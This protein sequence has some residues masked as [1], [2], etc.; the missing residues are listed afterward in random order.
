MFYYWH[1]NLTPN[2]FNKIAENKLSDA[3]AIAETKFQ[4]SAKTISIQLWRDTSISDFTSRMKITTEAPN[5]QTSNIIITT[6]NRPR[7]LILANHNNNQKSPL[8]GAVEFSEKD[9]T[10]HPVWDKD[11]NT[12]L[13]TK[14]YG[15]PIKIQR[16]AKEWHVAF[17]NPIQTTP[18]GEITLPF[19][20]P[21][22]E[23]AKQIALEHIDAELDKMQTSLNAFRLAIK[24]EQARIRQETPDDI[25]FKAIAAMYRYCDKHQ[26]LPADSGDNVYCKNGFH[27]LEARAVNNS[28]IL[29]LYFPEYKT[30]DIANAKPERTVTVQYMETSDLNEF[31]N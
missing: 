1:L 13:S 5:N 30:D 11:N 16:N 20:S 6:P 12:A 18:D 4:N 27:I 22:P 10:K 28:A 3:D 31:E 8:F 15:Q 2:Q 17:T 21:S 29:K 24:R 26:N 25:V 14:I 23:T 7:I 19:R 9:A